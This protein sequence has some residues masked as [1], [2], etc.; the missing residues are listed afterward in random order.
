[1]QRIR[2]RDETCKRNEHVLTILYITPV[3]PL[4]LDTPVCFAASPSLVASL[5]VRP[6]LMLASLPL[7]ETVTETFDLWTLSR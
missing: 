6:Y 5:T 4:W 1:M 2:D 3:A 7:T